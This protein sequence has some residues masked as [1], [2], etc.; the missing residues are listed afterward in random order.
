MAKIIITKGKTLADTLD[1]YKKFFLMMLAP[2][3]NFFTHPKMDGI[4]IPN[5]PEMK[6]ILKVIPAVHNRAS[7]ASNTTNYSVPPGSD[8]IG[9]VRMV[10]SVTPSAKQVIDEVGDDLIE[11]IREANAKADEAFASPQLEHNSLVES[12]GE[13]ELALADE[14]E[15]QIQEEQVDGK[16]T[17]STDEAT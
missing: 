8:F 2:H 12:M 16:P 7:Y 3:D 6:Q 10:L 15:R 14:M 17:G 11:R 9:D 4:E 5:T 13:R 1:A